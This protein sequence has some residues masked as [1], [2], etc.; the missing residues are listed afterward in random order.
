MKC[1]R[2]SKP[3]AVLVALSMA[4]LSSAAGRFD[5]KL[6]LDKQIVHVLTRL[7][8]GPRPADVEQVRRLGV[9]KW[10]DQQLHPEQIAENP[11]LEAKVK[12]LETVYMATWQIADK[13]P[14]TPAAF[15]IRPPAITTLS[16]QISSR[17]FNG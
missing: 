9:D 1:F 8:F 12:P 10:I 14:Q 17:L 16:P 15:M 7:T 4:C 5:Q 13:Y 3:A 6:T 2:L 11:I